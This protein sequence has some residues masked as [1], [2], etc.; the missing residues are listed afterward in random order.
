MN[1][2][3]AFL[4]ASL[5]ALNPLTAS[6]EADKTSEGVPN[7]C[8]A[9]ILANPSGIVTRVNEEDSLQATF[10]FFDGFQYPNG[11]KTSCTYSLN[12]DTIEDGFFGIEVID[13]EIAE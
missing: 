4:T 10:S 5:A 8:Y 1:S 9:Y 6:A 2:K 12:P 11:P 13:F 7:V 3:I